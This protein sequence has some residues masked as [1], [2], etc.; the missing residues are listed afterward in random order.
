MTYQALRTRRCGDK[1]PL[2]RFHQRPKDVVVDSSFPEYCTLIVL[3]YITLLLN[4]TPLVFNTSHHFR[5]KNCVRTER[6]LTFQQV[7][8]ELETDSSISYRPGFLHPWPSQW[9]RDVIQGQPASSC[10][11]CRPKDVRTC[12]F[13]SSGFCPTQAWS[14]ALLFIIS[15]LTVSFF[16]VM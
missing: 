10:F 6:A 4:F 16:L 2:T 3:Y 1:E 7:Q 9:N 5:T 8:R 13:D 11:S 15:L 12:R 14:I